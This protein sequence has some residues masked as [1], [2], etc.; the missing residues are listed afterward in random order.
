M[1]NKS[2]LLKQMGE[3]VPAN[4][5]ALICVYKTGEDWK[6]IALSGE[7]VTLARG[8]GCIDWRDFAT[9]IDFRSTEKTRK[10]AQDF[11]PSKTVKEKSKLHYDEKLPYHV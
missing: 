10:A 7:Q 8:S 3:V 11:L 6:L 1:P 4:V 2:D 5:E 9:Q